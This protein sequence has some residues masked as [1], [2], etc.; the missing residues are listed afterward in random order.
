MTMSPKDFYKKLHTAFAD[1]GSRDVYV[2]YQERH[3]YDELYSVMC[4]LNTKLSAYRGQAIGVYSGKSFSAYGAI[5]ASIISGNTWVPINPVLP[6][7]RIVNMLDAAQAKVLIVDS[8]LSDE[9]SAYVVANEIELIDLRNLPKEETSFD[10][11]RIDDDGVAYVMFTSGSTGVPKGVP[12][13]HVN[14]INFIENALNILPFED[15]D[16]FSDYHDFGFD[17]SIFYLFCA[18]LVGGAFAPGVDDRDSLMPLRHIQENKVTVLSSVPSI[19]S[20]VRQLN[21]RGPV[22]TPIRIAFLCGEPFR[23]DILE[24]CQDVLEL[25]NI[26][27]FYGLTETGV[28]NFY[29]P[30]QKGDVE[31]YAE[32][33]YVPIGTPL[34]GNDVDISEDGELVLAGEQLMSGYLGGRGVERFFEEDGKRWFLTGDRVV[35]YK[36]K[37]FC[38]GRLDSQV[39]VSGYRVDL[40]DIEAH[41]RRI[42]GISEAVSF[43]VSM[44]GREFIVGAYQGNPNMDGEGIRAAL[45]KMLP[46][47]M[48][49]R[50]LMNVDEMPLN[51]NGKV[52]RPKIR[53]LYEQRD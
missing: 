18:P 10:L 9:F 7:N 29:H 36:D 48:I 19:I 42:D 17:L 51:K 25:P 28:E 35:L 38:K 41:L 15:G 45:S 31:T 11:S 32:M 39:K 23:L 2:H 47:Y 50:S 5:F 52:D 8:D 27:N 49:P 16:V 46:D 26:Y 4:R 40:M 3:S 12:M 13:T 14:Y 34:P 43:V 37:Y 24:Y 30:C 6:W 21:P 1:G 33:G 20:R 44:G 22:D 53:E